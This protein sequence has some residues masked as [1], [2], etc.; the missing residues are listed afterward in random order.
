MESFSY[1]EASRVIMKRRQKALKESILES[2]EISPNFFTPFVKGIRRFFDKSP[3]LHYWKWL[4]IFL[5]F[6][7]S[8]QYGFYSV[9]LYKVTKE[10]AESFQNKDIIYTLIFAVDIFSKIFYLAYSSQQ[11]SAP[12]KSSHNKIFDPEI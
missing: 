12:K 5:S 9:F 10:E 8:F 6:I 11:T 2:V 7:S 3:L 4:I 1:S